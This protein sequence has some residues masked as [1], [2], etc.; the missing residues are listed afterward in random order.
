MENQSHLWSFYF[1]YI[2]SKRYNKYNII[3]YKY[4]KIKAIKT[5]SNIKY[6]LFHNGGYKLVRTGIPVTRVDTNNNQKK[7][8]N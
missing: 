4:Q 5:F 3:K 8:M 6:Y 2:S 7:I 1:L